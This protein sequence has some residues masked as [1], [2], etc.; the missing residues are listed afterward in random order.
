VHGGFMLGIGILG[1]WLAGTLAGR[2]AGGSLVRPLVVTGLAAGVAT[3]LNPNGIDGAL[4]PLRYVG[5]GLSESIREERTGTLSSPYAWVHLALLVGLVLLT[6]WRGRST[7]LPHAAVAGALA[8]LSMPRIAGVELPLA[9]ERHSPLLLLVGSPLLCWRLSELGW[10]RRL[11][12]PRIRRWGWMLP[13]AA[14]IA[15]IV[16]GARALPR[17][18]SPEARLLSGRFPEAGTEWLRQQ[19][20]PGNI[21]NPYAWGG[22]L[23]FHLWPQYHVWIDS[24][25]DLYGPE[26]IREVMLLHTLHP[27]NEL[28]VQELLQRYDAN[29]VV[30]HL[31]TLDFGPLQV[32]P[33]ADWLLQ[34]GEWRLVFYDRRNRRGPDH[35]TGTTAIF[36]RQ[37]ARNAALLERLPP[38]RLPPLP[39]PRRAWAKTAPVLP[40]E[41]PPRGAPS[42]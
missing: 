34:S 22:Y 32:H 39:G 36:L 23:A 17:D 7:P 5:S 25:G 20:L 10:M 29:V 33:F 16:W 26:R 3:L 37:D 31:L 12:G 1:L 8:W 6:A 27:G 14:A 24:R 4:Y 30:W 35:P 28:A 38:V 41:A 13:A 11:P 2:G 18:T 40:H 19:Q 21:I 42:R 15:A 9:A